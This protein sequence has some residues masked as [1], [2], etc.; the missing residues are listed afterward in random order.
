MTF[1]T[2]IRAERLRKGWTH[3]QVARRAG[4]S[5]TALVYIENGQTRD[6]R[7]SLVVALCDA[8]GVRWWLHGVDDVPTTM[9]RR[10]Q[11]NE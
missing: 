3:R 2:M 6:P 4:I 9:G 10:R 5:P 11:A 1:G 7:L 8:L